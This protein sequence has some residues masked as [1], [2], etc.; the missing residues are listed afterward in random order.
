MKVLKDFYVESNN[1]HQFGKPT[2]DMTKFEI[3][4]IILLIYDMYDGVFIFSIVCY[5]PPHNQNN[6]KQ[7]VNLRKS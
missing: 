1:F 3:V 5:F 6:K 2:R 4:K 7:P